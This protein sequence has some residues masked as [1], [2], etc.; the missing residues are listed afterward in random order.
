MRSFTENKNS[1]NLSLKH[2]KVVYLVIT[3]IYG[4]YG[5]TMVV[6]ELK[7]LLVKVNVVI[8]LRDIVYTSR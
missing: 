4:L 3:Q 5:R 2:D 6:R 7:S 8:G 1:F